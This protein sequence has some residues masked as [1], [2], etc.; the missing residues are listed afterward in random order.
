MNA[1]SVF[2]A[3]VFTAAA[4][5]AH[6]QMAGSTVT[7]TAVIQ[8]RELTA[9]WSVSRQLLGRAVL[10]EHGQPIG[11][12]DDIIVAPDASVSHVIVGTAGGFLGM[13]RHEVAVPLSLLLLADDVFVLVGSGP[14]SLALMPAFEYAR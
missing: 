3:L 11:R 1:R 5:L 9:G 7:A 13:R 2:S 12:V 4:G 8:V 14:G 10:N 6:G